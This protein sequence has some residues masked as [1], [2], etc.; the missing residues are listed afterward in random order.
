VKDAAG[1]ELVGTGIYDFV[2]SI[3]AVGNEG[4]AGLP[5]EK[6]TLNVENNGY[7]L[8][9]MFQNINVTY[10]G[11]SNSDYGLYVMFG[12]PETTKL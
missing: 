5:P 12:A 4:K 1:K 2:K 6:M 11:E 7:K 9:I 10:G 8:R 3:S